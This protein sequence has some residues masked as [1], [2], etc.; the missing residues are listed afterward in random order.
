MFG[1]IG[2]LNAKSIV[3]PK[4]LVSE[5]ILPKKHFEGNITLSGGCNVHYSI[6]ANFSWGCLCVTEIHGSFSMSGNCSGNQQFRSGFVKTD[7][8]G[9][10]IDFNSAEVTVRELQSEEFKKAF[11]EVLNKERDYSN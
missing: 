9:V 3:N 4:L 10:V 6:D 1:F 5:N 7:K 11:I 8:E 2:N